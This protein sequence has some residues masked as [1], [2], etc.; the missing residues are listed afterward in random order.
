[1]SQHALSFGGQDALSPFVELGAY[2]ALWARA[3]MSTKKLA[4]LFRGHPNVTPSS[5]VPRDEAVAM[6]RKAVASLGDAPFGV[7]IHRAAEYPLRLRDAANPVELLYFQGVWEL[8][9]TPCVAVV[10]TREPS[11][12][13]RARTRKLVR[14]LV[15]DGRTVVSGL[16]AGIDTI[17]HTTAI[18]AG[19]QTIAVIGT[20]LGHYYP[21][22]NRS[23]QDRIR[24]EFLLIS[25][26]PVI[27]YS[28]QSPRL[29]RLFFPERNHTMSALSDATVIVEA[30]ETSG[31]LIQARAALAQGRKLFILESCF[32]RG[33][34]WPEKF[35]ARG[36]IR[37][38]DYAD[39][40]GAL[41]AAPAHR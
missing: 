37:V 14:A 3:G 19:G 1:M 29:N 36:A 33:L 38:R 11:D 40:R 6:A 5:L 16:A 24:R 22:E 31:T 4:D 27:R 2:E 23:L 41:A 39:I 13:G 15:E 8:V 18:E 20:P 7:R 17:A 26:V 28:Q 30:G 25:H 21:I 35:L 32:A 10:G 12:D 9:E 34:A